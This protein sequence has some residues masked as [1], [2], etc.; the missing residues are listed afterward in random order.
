MHSDDPSVINL[1]GCLEKA[2]YI[3]TN[4]G[5]MDALYAKVEDVLTEIKHEK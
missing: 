4:E 3:I 5:S 2:D 1:Q